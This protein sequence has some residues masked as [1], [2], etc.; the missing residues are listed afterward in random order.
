M[1][2]WLALA[3]L[4]F[5]TAAHG[6][7]LQESVTA[8][9]VHDVPG[10]PQG[11]FWHPAAEHILRS[12]TDPAS[13]YPNV[14]VCARPLTLATPHCTSVC[15]EFK[16]DSHGDGQPSTEC[17]RP[18]R[19]RLAPNDQVDTLA[20]TGVSVW[21]KSKICGIGQWIGLSGC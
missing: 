12:F 20:K 21:L 19:A 8:V 2:Q 13:I 10:P 17:Q 6:Q 16:G 14:E 5:V 3:G 9:W 18:Q 1:K 15:W 11:D 7:G 4:L